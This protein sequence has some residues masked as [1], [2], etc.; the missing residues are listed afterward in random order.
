MGDMN[1][2]VGNTPEFVIP[3]VG[4]ITID[5]IALDMY[6]GVSEVYYYITEQDGGKVSRGDRI[7]SII[8]TD[9]LALPIVSIPISTL[10]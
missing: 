6:H 1:F 5:I 7:R 9:R 4:T 10:K 3:S 8:R 2:F